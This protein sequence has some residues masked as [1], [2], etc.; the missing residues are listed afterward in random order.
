MGL[1]IPNAC[2]GNARRFVVDSKPILYG[3]LL[4]IFTAFQTG[5][6]LDEVPVMVICGLWQILAVLN[7]VEEG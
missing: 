5:E 7:P 6:V 1:G 3:L 2:L 4:E